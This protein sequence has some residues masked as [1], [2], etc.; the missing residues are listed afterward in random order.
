MQTNLLNI[1][2][3]YTL[4]DKIYFPVK[5]NKIRHPVIPPSHP[6]TVLRPFKQSKVLVI[7]TALPAY[8]G[9]RVEKS[10]RQKKP[11]CQTLRTSATPVVFHI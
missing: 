6:E 9:P 4:V 5:I 3:L 1:A 2:E 8:N 7:N 10:L 11:E